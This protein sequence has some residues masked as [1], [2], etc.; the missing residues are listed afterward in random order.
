MLL[1][2]LFGVVFAIE[3]ICAVLLI[4]IILIQQSKSAGGLGAIGGG[5]TESVFGAAAGN[6]LT[7]TT[8]ILT[9]IFLGATLVLAVLASHKGKAPSLADKLAGGAAPTPVAE[10]P[11]AAVPAS[12]ASVPAMEVASPDAVPP[13]EAPAA[14][15]ETAP[16][17][18]PAPAEPAKN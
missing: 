11:A 2:V 18:A 5:M 6:I 3:L 17:P 1:S 12:D 7:R 15:P 9:G 4:G 13:L 14:A 10:E 8:V 16:A